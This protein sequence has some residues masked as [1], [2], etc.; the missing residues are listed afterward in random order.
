MQYEEIAEPSRSGV[1]KSEGIH[2]VRRALEL[3]TISSLSRRIDFDG[4]RG[5]RFRQF[6]LVRSA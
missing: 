6:L 5:E 2:A 4:S 1:S 3:F